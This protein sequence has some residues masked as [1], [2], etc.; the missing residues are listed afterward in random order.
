VRGLFQ[1]VRITGSPG[2]LFCGYLP[3]KE[4][5]K[6]SEHYHI[7]MFRYLKGLNDGYFIGFE[8][9]EDK[10]GRAMYGFEKFALRCIAL[11]SL[12]IV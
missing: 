10:I 5:Y 4:L 1:V 3:V 12:S 7:C 9:L 8:S 11:H 2:L 6:E